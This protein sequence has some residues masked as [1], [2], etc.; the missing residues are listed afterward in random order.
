MSWT[1]AHCGKENYQDDEIAHHPPRCVRCGQHR[2][3]PEERIAELSAAR[4]DLLARIEKEKAALRPLY[5][6]LDDLQGEEARLRV[7]IYDREEQVKVA[8][9]A[10]TSIDRMIVIA[11][12]GPA[13]GQD[14]AQGRLAL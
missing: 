9:D 7:K 5:Q 4:A 2:I 6:D 1:C 13:R 12:E 10:I 14:P 3:S 11:R 8:T